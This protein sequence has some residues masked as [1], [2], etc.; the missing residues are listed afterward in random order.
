MKQSSVVVIGG[1][2]VGVTTAEAFARRGVS[3]TL[4]ERSPSLGSGV[5]ARNGGQLSYS[6]VDALGSPSLLRSI[7]KMLLGC[8][9]GFRIHTGLRPNFPAWALQFLL[10]CTHVRST[11]NTRAVLRLALRSRAALAALGARHTTLEFKHAACGKLHIYDDLRKFEAATAAMT[12]KNELGCEQ[13]I[14]SID[15]LLTLEPALSSSAR[16]IVGAIYSPLDEAGDSFQFTN[17]LAD[18][19]E[20]KYGLA[21]HTSTAVTELITDHRRVRAVRTSHGLVEGDIFVLAA[22]VNSVALAGSV[23]VTLPIYP[24]KGYS[25]TLPA[26]PNSPT[27]SIT[28][29][30]SRI[31][32]CRLNDQVRIAGLAELGRADGELDSRRIEVLLDAARTCLPVA[33]DWRADP[34]P[35]SGLR[36]MTPD[37]RPIIGS[38]PIAN[39]FLN[40]GHGM[41]GWTLACGSAEMT[42]S[43]ILE[44]HR[45]E[46]Y[47]SIASDFSLARF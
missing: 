22:G 40:C 46:E 27:V 37:C 4:L 44:E 25:V 7:P 8:D 38:T 10:N 6:Y 31:V 41:L 30:S 39:L 20:Q 35:W 12:L 47:R 43:L 16:R 9:Q 32:F 28:D 33:A 17:E 1:G 26:T 11:E 21:V 5:T 24:M 42:A 14:L 45:S 36:P 2:V 15:E 3:V 29:T 34:N 13:R 18:I 19:L 23:G